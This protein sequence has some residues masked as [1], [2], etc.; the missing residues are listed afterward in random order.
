MV[1]QELGVLL[2]QHDNNIEFNHLNNRIHC[3]PQIINI[4]ASHII[5]S[6]THIS[7]QFLET[8]KFESDSDLVYFNIKGD[9]NNNN[10][11]DGHL[12]AQKTDIPKLVLDK[13]Q[14]NNILDDELQAWYLGLKQDPIK[15]TRRIVC[16]VR[17]SD[18]RRQV[19]K[20]VINTGNHSGWFRSHDNEII[21]LPNL[22]LLRDVKTQWDSVYCMSERLLALQPVSVHMYRH[23]LYSYC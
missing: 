4:C 1:M 7:K 14:V 3:Y 19:F 17:S 8:L 9:D 10:N 5:A 23:P 6:S 2:K 18:Q 15:H 11:N 12:F 13:E 22:E 20:N 16:I 21:K